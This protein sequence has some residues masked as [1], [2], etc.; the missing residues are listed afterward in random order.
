MLLHF[1]F[2]LAAKVVNIA[3]MGV[4]GAAV[5]ARELAQLFHRDALDGFLAKQGGERLADEHTG[6]ARAVVIC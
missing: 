5:D 2:D 4:K 6:H 3:V 1:R